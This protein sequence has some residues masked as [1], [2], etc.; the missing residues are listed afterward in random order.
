[1]YSPIDVHS[2]AAGTSS[3]LN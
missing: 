3:T 1:M 2:H